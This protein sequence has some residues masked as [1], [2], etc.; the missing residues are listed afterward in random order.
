[1]PS[2]TTRSRAPAPRRRRRFGTAALGALVALFALVASDTPVSAQEAPEFRLK[3]A[4]LYN[5]AQFT[6]WPADV[7]PTLHLCV[8]GADPFGA[9]LDALHGKAVGE[10]AI[11]VTRRL[12]ADGLR[13]CQVVFVANNAIAQ[14]PRVLETLRGAP[15]LV[16]ADGAGA[17]KRGATLALAVTDGR[18]AFEANL[19]A[20]RSA[21]LQLSSRL[22]RLAAE[23][24]P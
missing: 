22:L 3:A 20:A 15:V 19:D 1:M 17:A 4:F 10:R 14:L 24:H 13:G 8:H 2:T 21:R 12:P 5:F 18:I 9:E 6:E 7:G 16:V 23:V 11:A